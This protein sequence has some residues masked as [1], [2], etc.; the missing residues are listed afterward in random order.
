MKRTLSFVFGGLLC[1]S[2]LAAQSSF[3]LLPVAPTVGADAVSTYLF[4][5]VDV[6][7]APAIQP[8]ATLGFG[9]SGLTASIWSSFALA[10]RDEVVPLGFARGSLD[11]VDLTAAY[12]RAAGPVSFGAGYIAYIFPA[13][14]LDYVTQE[15][16]GTLGAAGIPLAPTLSVYYDFDDGV[17]AEDGNL[18]TIEGV[19]AQLGVS[20]RFP[21]GLPLDVGANVSWTEQEALRAESGFNDFNVWAGVP[22]PFQGITIVPTVGFTQLL[23]GALIDDEGESTLWAKIQLRLP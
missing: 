10:D 23:E 15:V 11:E 13:G 6:T 3:S 9:N 22:I 17:D 12:S 20:Q 19:Y 4:R 2:Q 21:I 18:D 1:A 14:S 7:E 16:Y 8:F 5:G